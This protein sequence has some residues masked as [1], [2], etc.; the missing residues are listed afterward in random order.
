MHESWIDF[1]LKRDCV[2]VRENWALSII[3]DSILV[4]VCERNP[5][6]NSLNKKGFL[7]AHMMWKFQVTS[8]RYGCIQLLKWCYVILLISWFSFPPCGCNLFSAKV[9]SWQPCFISVAPPR[10]RKHLF[11]SS[12]SKS[13]RIHCT[14]STLGPC[15]CPSCS[16]HHEC[17]PLFHLSQTYLPLKSC[18]SSI[19]VTFSFCLY[20]L[21]YCIPFL[22][23]LFSC[24]VSNWAVSYLHC[25][26]HVRPGSLADQS[27]ISCLSFPSS[28]YLI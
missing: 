12:S 9:F 21:F 1:S 20:C 11:P 27:F 5:P 28:P 14:W 4:V 24:F 13:P 16:D 22:G 6:G 10:K 23:Q 3:M 19:A 26:H 17:P 18:L 8:F 2:T 15:T 25:V 7:L